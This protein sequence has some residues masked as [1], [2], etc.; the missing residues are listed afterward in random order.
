MG[1]GTSYSTTNRCSLLQSLSD[2]RP[3]SF[4]LFRREENRPITRRRNHPI[5]G[6]KTKESSG[7]FVAG[8]REGSPARFGLSKGLKSG[9][10]AKIK[11]SQNKYFMIL[12]E[13]I[14]FFLLFFSL[15]KRVS[16]FAMAYLFNSINIIYIVSSVLSLFHSCAHR[17]SDACPPPYGRT[18]G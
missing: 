11:Q 7:I 8:R 5:G 2:N 6:K 18:R 10:S 4:Y 12:S 17:Y 15:K 13:D 3:I 16:L 14:R 9:W 1:L